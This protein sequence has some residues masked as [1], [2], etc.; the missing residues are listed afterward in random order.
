MF[1]ACWRTLHFRVFVGAS[2]KNRLR[3]CCADIT[4]PRRVLV[5]GGPQSMLRFEPVRL[6]TAMKRLAICAC[7]VVP[8]LACGSTSSPVP[9]APSIPTTSNAS[10]P[11]TTVLT[12][13]QW[14]GTFQFL[15]QWIGWPGDA[16]FES[17]TAGMASVTFEAGCVT[18][19]TYGEA[20]I[21]ISRVPIEA[22]PGLS[23]ESGSYQGQPPPSGPFLYNAS[24]M[25]P[26]GQ[27][28][29]RVSSAGVGWTG[30]PWTITLTRPE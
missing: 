3:R 28:R 1:T 26:A 21:D 7:L 25:L 16:S 20:H 29:M 27:Y 11:A 8:A 30:C 15:D 2:T 12:T 19:G 9:T 22:G 18:F 23:L 17:H 13:S 14:T 24:T 4:F 6:E 5:N 10:V